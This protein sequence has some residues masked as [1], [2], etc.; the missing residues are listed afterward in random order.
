MAEVKEQRFFDRYDTIAI[1]VPG[2]SLLLGLWH[3]FPNLFG[4]VEIKEFSLGGFGVL[5]VAAF[6]VG[7]ILQAPA[8]VVAD[9]G[10]NRF[11]RP[12]E[13]LAL[14]GGGFTA[15]QVEKIRNKIS[16][17]LDVGPPPSGDRRAWRSIVGQVA[18]LV[19]N[20]GKTD[21]LEKFNGNYGLFRG[22]TAALTILAVVAIT[23]RA[24]VEV[25]V[26][27]PL[28]WA[29]RFRMKRFGIYYAREL[30]LQ[31][32]TLADDAGAESENRSAQRATR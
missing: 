24:W 15:D 25:G 13:K 18:V 9:F 26:L 23:Q 31:F 32:L 21:R 16:S 8:N 29:T 27:T 6:C 3:F 10:W 1:V 7:H 2:A 17:C 5:A 30:W 14:A 20:D 12:T 22:L 28:A 11:G 19:S 4:G